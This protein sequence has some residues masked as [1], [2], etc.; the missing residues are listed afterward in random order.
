MDEFR[1]IISALGPYEGGLGW[2]IA[3]YV[4]FFLNV[5]LLIMEGSSFA[6]NI[7][8]VVLL[9]LFIDKTFAFGYM[10]NPS[11][12]DPRLCHSEVFFGTYIARVIMFAGPFAIAGSTR[13]GRTR[14]VAIVA[15]IGGM[16]YMFARWWYEQRNSDVSGVTCM[17]DTGIMMQ[18]AGLL[19][20]LARITLRDRFGFGLV[21]GHIPV[22][23]LGELAPDDVEI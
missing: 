4:L 11:D 18:H 2:S 15:G 6:T 16:T 21:N 7:T 9:A 12:M 1:E 8:I 20:V 3:L 19:L 13:N 10:F 22:T 23:V 14:F 17:V 5:I